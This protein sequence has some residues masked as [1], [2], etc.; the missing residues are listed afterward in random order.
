MSSRSATAATRRTCRSRTS[1]AA[2]RG[3]RSATTASRSTPSTAAPRGCSSRISTSGRARSGCAGSRC[4][5]TTSPAS[6]SATATTTTAIRGGSSGTGATD[7]GG[8]REVAD[9]VEETPSTRTLVLDVD[10][11]TGHR[12]GQ[13][14]DIRLTAEDGYQARALVLDRV[15]AGATRVALTVER[16]DDGEVSPYLVDEVRLGDTFE[17]RGPIGGY[18]AWEPADGGP[19]LLVGGG[20]GV[21]PLRAMLRRA[22][23]D[24][25]ARLLY[26]SRTLDDVIYREEL[27]GARRRRRPHADARAARRRA[28][29]PGRCGAAAGGG[30]SARRRSRV[31]SSAAR[32]PSS[33]R[34]RRRWSDSATRRS[35]SGPSASARRGGE[36]GSSWTE[37]AQRAC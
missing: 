14:V 5:S 27:D 24:V 23:A 17:L 4:A 37:T 29:R 15:G 13:H 1:P 6:G 3:S 25:P 9:V 18:F 32:R 26:S 2:R 22:T 21:V 36:H 30:F 12:A 34:S 28:R 33:R 19:L 7:A 20:S 31:I 8:S 10:G 11:W 35:G 16:I